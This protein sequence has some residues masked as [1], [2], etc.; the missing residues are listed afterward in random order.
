MAS[1]ATLPPASPSTKSIS[2]RGRSRRSGVLANGPARRPGRGRR[3]GGRRVT[4]WRCRSRSMV[5]LLGPVGAA[6]VEGDGDQAAAHGG[7][8]RQARLEHL[9]D[10]AVGVGDPGDRG[11][12]DQQAADVHVHGR[13]LAVQEHGVEPAD[14][15][16]LAFVRVVGAV[17]AAHLVR[18]V[19]SW[20]APS[21]RDLVVGPGRPTWGG[22]VPGTA[23]ILP[24]SR[25]S[26]SRG[27]SGALV[28][29]VDEQAQAGRSGTGRSAGPAGA[30]RR[31]RGPSARAG[32][33]RPGGWRPRPRCRRS[34]G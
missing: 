31:G 8:G 19:R 6:H 27:L 10:G 29:G 13:R 32:R 4:R 12:E 25:G 22:R 34:A 5:G 3:R 20:S 17:R 16:G 30:A 18:L 23:P 26:F 28:D 1:R 2:H 24:V 33:A 14:L 9:A 15:L 11:V 21:A 7:D